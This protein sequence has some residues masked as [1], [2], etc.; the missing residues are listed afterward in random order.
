MKDGDDGDIEFDGTG[1]IHAMQK[2][3]GK[4]CL[5]LL[6]DWPRCQLIILCQFY[7]HGQLS[8]ANILLLGMKYSVKDVV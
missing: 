4:Y 5:P 2:M 1:F 7:F 6:N 8:E 3:F